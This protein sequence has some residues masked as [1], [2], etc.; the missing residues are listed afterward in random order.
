VQ[1]AADVAGIF[2]RKRQPASSF[3]LAY[4]THALAA[5]VLRGIECVR[6]RNAY[7][8]ANRGT[9]INLFFADLFLFLKR[10]S[11]SKTIFAFEKNDLKWRVPRSPDENQ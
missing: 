9:L 2:G 4:R 7:P 10:A 1:M 3:Y 11:G 6:E 5:L 8:N